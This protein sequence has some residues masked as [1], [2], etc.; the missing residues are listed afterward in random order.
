M[1]L[2]QSRNLTAGG[3]QLAALLPVVLANRGAQIALV[4][5]LG[6]LA[7]ALARKTV[8]RALPPGRAAAPYLDSPRLRTLAG[9]VNSILRYSVYFLVAVTTLSLLGVDTRSLLVG[10]GL[11]GLAV[12]F[13]AQGLVRDF[14]GGFLI[15]LEDQFAVG[16]LVRMAG[17]EGVVEEMGLRTTRLRALGGE[18]H[19]IPNGRIQ[20]VTNLSRG[21]MDVSFT[22]SVPYE[23]DIDHV[24]RVIDETLL[25]YSTGNPAIVQAP[26]VRGIEDLTETSVRLLVG[27]R[28]RPMEQGPVARD[29]RLQVKR[30]LDAAGL[31]ATRP[32][33]PS[34]RESPRR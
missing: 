29:L 14:L 16:D 22:V 33:L 3:G 31:A 17:L 11:F 25:R 26:A 12:G 4:I 20:E 32:S 13:G 23:A 2:D 30:A 5:V 15:L 19:V 7:L 1:L 18:L 9:L 6:W 8:A 21:D 24:R 28:T 27:G 10:A 34:A